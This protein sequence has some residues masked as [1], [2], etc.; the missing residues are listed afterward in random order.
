M[1]VCINQQWYCDYF[2]SQHFVANHQ[3]N[4]THQRNGCNNFSVLFT[5]QNQFQA[6]AQLEGGKMGGGH[7]DDGTYFLNETIP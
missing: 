7:M 6:V 4:Y 3:Y 1:S 2:H 5:Q